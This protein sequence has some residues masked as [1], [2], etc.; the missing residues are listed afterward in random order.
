MV[1]FLNPSIWFLFR[2]R[3][4]SCCFCW[5]VSLL[6]SIQFKMRIHVKR[7]RKT[8]S[9]LF[10]NDAN[11]TGSVTN[12]VYTSQWI[13]FMFTPVNKFRLCLHQWTRIPFT[14]TKFHFCLHQWMMQN[15]G[16]TQILKSWSKLIPNKAPCVKTKVTWLVFYFHS[17]AVDLTSWIHLFYRNVIVI[18]QDLLH[19]QLFVTKSKPVAHLKDCNADIL[20]KL[21]SGRNF[22]KTGCSATIRT[23]RQVPTYVIKVIN[24]FFLCQIL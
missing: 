11:E 24:S 23:S 15:N 22:L 16:E 3:A 21:H 6:K 18:S 17:E 8:K 2:R 10:G 12:S 9:Q 14:L 4:H 7:F 20:V 5:L 19:N 1:P 13:P